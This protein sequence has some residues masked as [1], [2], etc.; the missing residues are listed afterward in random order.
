MPHAVYA[1]V[2]P[3]FDAEDIIHLQLKN[4]SRVFHE[5]VIFFKNWPP[6]FF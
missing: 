2:K 4:V 5:I 1:L 3:V 6:Q